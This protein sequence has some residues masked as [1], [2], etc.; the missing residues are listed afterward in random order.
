[1]YEEL[2]Y[3]HA[4]ARHQKSFL[5]TLTLVTALRGLASHVV[6]FGRETNGTAA[7]DT[8]A[9]FSLFFQPFAITCSPN[10]AA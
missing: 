3:R 1:M 2:H 10:G 5:M 4:L 8:H 7:N 6:D 9:F